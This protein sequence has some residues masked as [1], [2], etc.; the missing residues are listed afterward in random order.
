MTTSECGGDQGVTCGPGARDWFDWTPYIILGAVAFGAVC[1][2]L[3]RR[4]IV[5]RRKKKMMQSELNW[6]ASAFP[7][8][9]ARYVDH[10]AMASLDVITISTVASGRTH[11][12]S[13]TSSNTLSE[14]EQ[15][16]Q[17]TVLSFTTD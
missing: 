3:I 15:P 4:Q 12:L 7:S 13:S 14:S 1:A 5:Q 8:S 9:S 11:S 17:R 2:T 10:T 16:L 6:P